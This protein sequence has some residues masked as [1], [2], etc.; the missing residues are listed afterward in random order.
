MCDCYT[1]R[2][3]ICKRGMEIHIADFCTPRDNVFPFCPDCFGALPAWLAEHAAD[4]WEWQLAHSF[5]S[6]PGQEVP[7]ANS[8]ISGLTSGV[9]IFAIHDTGAYD[10]GLNG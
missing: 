5:V 10:I 2:C 7:E 3:T 9:A 6:R 8:T 1:G 4:E